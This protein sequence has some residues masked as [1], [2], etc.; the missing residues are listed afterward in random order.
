MGPAVTAFIRCEGMGSGH[1]GGSGAQLFVSVSVDS[2]QPGWWGG[3]CRARDALLYCLILQEG[4]AMVNLICLFVVK[5]KVKWGIYYVA[6]TSS[7]VD[8]VGLG[9]NF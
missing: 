9:P 4:H 1:R 6:A 2:C 8:W 7:F 3:Q 5:W